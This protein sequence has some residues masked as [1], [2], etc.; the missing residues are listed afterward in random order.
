MLL[1]KHAAVRIRPIPLKNSSRRMRRKLRLRTP[2]ACVGLCRS[3]PAALPPNGVRCGW[4]TQY[5]QASSTENKM[6]LSNKSAHAVGEIF[7]RPVSQRS[8]SYPLDAAFGALLCGSAQSHS[9]RFIF[10]S[11][12]AK[13]AS[14]RSDA[15]A[16]SVLRPYRSLLRCW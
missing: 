9:G 3:T 4:R 11:I 2:S 14:P 10:L 6:N 16:G 13:R 15:N 1:G 8:R 7:E 5:G 12:A